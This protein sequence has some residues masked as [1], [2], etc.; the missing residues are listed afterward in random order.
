MKEFFIAILVVAV[1]VAGIFFFTSDAFEE[2]TH[3]GQTKVLGQWVDDAKI[4]KY[5]IDSFKEIDAELKGDTY[6][7]NC[8]KITPGRVRICR[9]C[10]QYVD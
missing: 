7:E 9:Y 4:D 6:C 2:M 1:A 8:D 5:D 10:G 3:P